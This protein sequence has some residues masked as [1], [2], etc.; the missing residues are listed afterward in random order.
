MNLNIITQKLPKTKYMGGK[1][2][3]KFNKDNDIIAPTR[4]AIRVTDKQLS[5]I[6]LRVRY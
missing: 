6:F 5:V 3:Q 1:S 2:K 4:G